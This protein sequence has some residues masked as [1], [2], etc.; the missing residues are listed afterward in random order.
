MLNQLEQHCNAVVA[1][2]VSLDALLG[3][4]WQTQERLFSAFQTIRSDEA[5]RGRRVPDRPQD[6]VRGLSKM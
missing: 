1:E 6:L 5:L 3:E 2:T 4:A